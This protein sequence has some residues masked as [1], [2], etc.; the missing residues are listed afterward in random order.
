MQHR[1]AKKC[2]FHFFVG[3]ASSSRV[4]HAGSVLRCSE[5]RRMNSDCRL[6]VVPAERAEWD[7]RE[8]G[9]TEGRS[10]T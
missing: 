9:F 7:I 8:Q 5:V 6:T 4:H 10:G 3:P 2:G 1:T